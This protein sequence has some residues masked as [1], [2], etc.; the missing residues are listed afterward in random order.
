ML[1]ILYLQI[2]TSV[3][4]TKEDVRVCVKIQ[5]VALNVAAPW[6]THLHLM[7]EN[8]LVNKLNGKN[9]NLINLTFPNNS[10]GPTI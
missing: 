8:V 1:K 2:S 3:A 10:K 4:L 9:A 6:D 7:D 5:K